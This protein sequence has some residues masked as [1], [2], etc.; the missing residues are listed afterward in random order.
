MIYKKDCAAFMDG[1]V[2]FLMCK[3]VAY[4]NYEDRICSVVSYGML[5]Y[6][7]H[8]SFWSVACHNQEETLPLIY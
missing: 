1:I 5:L 6:F 4:H 8:L 7:L 3:V 2:K